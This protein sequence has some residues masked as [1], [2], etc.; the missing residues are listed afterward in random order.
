[1][2]LHSWFKAGLVPIDEVLEY[3]WS[4]KSRRDNEMEE[5]DSDDDDF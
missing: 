3:L 5:L 2:V 1:M 4:L